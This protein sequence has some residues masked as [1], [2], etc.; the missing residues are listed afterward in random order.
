MIRASIFLL[1]LAG[2]GLATEKANDTLTISSLPDGAQVEWNRKVIGTTPLTQKVGE[3]AFNARKSSLFSKH[4]SQPVVLR[5][6][7]SGYAAREVTITREFNWRSLNGQNGFVFYVITSNTFQIDLD[8]IS[9][10]HAAITN[11]D[12]VKLKEAGFGDDLIIDKINTTPAAFNLEFD[13]LVSLRKAGISDAV[14][15]A[16]MHA[17]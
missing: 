11:A 9:A 3:Y 5:V 13:D 12:I 7:K 15:Q 16:M 10:V 1:T 2:L 14:I 17:K 4:L 6:S 8:K